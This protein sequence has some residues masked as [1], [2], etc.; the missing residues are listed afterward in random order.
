MM[1]QLKINGEWAVLPPGFSLKMMVNSPL[2]SDQ[3][4]LSYPFELPTEPNTH[5]FKNVAHPQGLVRLRDFHGK[6]AE[7]WFDGN[8]IFYGQTEV[9][10]DI[11]FSKPTF[12]LN[13]VSNNG[14]FK[15]M[16]S[17]LNCRD[18]NIIDK[19]KIGWRPS[20]VVWDT[21]E[22]EYTFSCFKDG[23]TKWLA[24]FQKMTPTQALDKRTLDIKPYLKD[25]GDLALPHVVF[26]ELEHNVSEP[27]PMKSYCNVR[28]C[29]PNAKD[30]SVQSESA[31]STGYGYKV[32][33]IDKNNNAP[34][35]FVLYFLDCLFSKENLNINYSND[36]LFVDGDR[37]RPKYEDLCRLAFLNAYPRYDDVGEGQYNADIPILKYDLREMIGA[38]T[39]Y[40]RLSSRMHYAISY[41]EVVGRKLGNTAVGIG[42][43]YSTN[44]RKDVNDN[45]DENLNSRWY[46]Y[47]CYANGKNFPDT[48]VQNVISDLTNAFGIVFDYDQENNYM[49]LHIVRDVMRDKDV[50]EPDCVIIDKPTIKR[51]MKNG[52]ILSY[53]ENEDINYNY[54]M[55]NGHDKYGGDDPKIFSDYLNLSSSNRM[56]TDAHTYYE[57]NTC[58]AYR[59]KVDESTGRE[60]Q[61]FSAA[62]YR[63]YKIG[64]IKDAYNRNH[65]Y[66]NS[67][68][69]YDQS[70]TKVYVDRDE[71]AAEKIT[72][73]YK[74]VTINDVWQYLANKDKVLGVDV[75][76][77]PSSAADQDL[78]VWVDAEGYNTHANV[79]VF[80]YISG[81]GMQGDKPH[82]DGSGKKA[83]QTTIKVLSSTAEMMSVN[84]VVEV[85]GVEV[86]ITMGI[87]VTIAGDCAFDL[88]AEEHYLAKANVGYTLGI[89]RGPGNKSQPDIQYN[90]DD[91][92][93]DTWIDTYDKPAFTADSIDLYGQVFDYNGEENG[94]ATLDGRLSLLLDARKVKEYDDDGNPVYFEYTNEEF[95]RRGLVPKLLEEFLYFKSHCATVS[96][97]VMMSLAQIKNIKLMKWNRFGDF[98]GLIKSVNYDIS[99]RGVE[100]AVIELLVLNS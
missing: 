69:V 82:M 81:S 29:C 72:I 5:I 74:P 41:N 16:V 64:I 23:I 66:Y 28:M 10:G 76:A 97:P 94:G 92:G 13:V 35:F 1:I 70:D 36:G 27:Y 46:K 37:T 49:Q 7:I 62:A 87:D 65:R 83:K 99:D 2:F 89:M 57:K 96:I 21:P 33:E 75:F 11:D 50:Q 30:E 93:N 51:S 80:D 14:A 52:V 3:G 86:R 91:E 47:D 43:E 38:D 9:S 34:S 4:N 58:G 42:Y 88:S 12:S 6:P 25:C 98:T 20:R 24:E 26:S 39:C 55:P 73:N 40:Y 63:D 77:Y 19:I 31:D 68:N 48:S 100:N 44:E 15:D 67:G 85:N 22:K 45:A 84:K 90:Y 79:G 60:P 32:L 61:F 71:D 95:A 8:L 59:I 56:R 18:V 54:R 53:G 17:G 78:C